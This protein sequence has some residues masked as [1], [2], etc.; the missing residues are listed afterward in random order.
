MSNI[1]PYLKFDYFFHLSLA[2]AINNDD[3]KALRLMVH[4]DRNRP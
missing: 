2:S 4:I 3:E 1:K